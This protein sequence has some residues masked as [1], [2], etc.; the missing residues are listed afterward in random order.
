ML[1]KPAA[2]GPAQQIQNAAERPISNRKRNGARQLA[3]R[4]QALK[5][6]VAGLAQLGDNENPL[7][8]SARKGRTL[9]EAEKTLKRAAAL[10][11]VR[12]H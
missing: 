12:L 11:G 5:L 1:R 9:A 4:Q 2:L 3:E 7:Y 10:L 6:V 8:K